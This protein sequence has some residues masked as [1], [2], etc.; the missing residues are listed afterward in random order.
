[1]EWSTIIFA[2]FL[3]V[4]FSVF[5][6]LVIGWRRPGPRNAEAVVYS[7]FF[8]TVILFLTVWAVGVWV[9]L[10][11]PVAFNVPW[12]WLLFVGLLV[13]L[14]IAAMRPSAADDGKAASLEPGEAAAVGAGISFWL[15]VVLLFSMVLAGAWV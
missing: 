15:L 9:P 4:A 5:G 1:M 13:F 10:G 14:L 12:L 3:A 2:L 7:M 6:V 11:G 8:F